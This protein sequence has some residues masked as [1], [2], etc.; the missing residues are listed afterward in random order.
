MKKLLM[1][2]LLLLAVSFVAVA[3]EVTQRP[4]DGLYEAVVGSAYMD[5]IPVPHIPW[6][7]L[8]VDSMNRTILWL[9]DT[10]DDGS[11][12]DE[13]VA[14]YRAVFYQDSIKII[15]GPFEG[16]FVF[17]VEHRI[18]RLLVFGEGSVVSIDFVL[19]ERW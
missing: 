9:D 6:L 19:L 18:Y 13:T 14:P 15:E 2:M 12:Q 16:F 5:G 8:G 3:E 10:D 11:L 17:I 1:V 7:R 4:I